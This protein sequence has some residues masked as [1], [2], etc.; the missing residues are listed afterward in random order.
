[1]FSFIC[2]SGDSLLFELSLL[3]FHVFFL[4]GEGETLV[5]ASVRWSCSGGGGVLPVLI[6]KP[7]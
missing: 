2:I 1:M 7:S 3:S 6:V 4:L 5:L